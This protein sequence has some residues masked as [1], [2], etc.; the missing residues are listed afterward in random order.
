M[1]GKDERKGKDGGQR[2]ATQNQSTE[3][4]GNA[5]HAGTVS[6]SVMVHL[7]ILKNCIHNERI[8]N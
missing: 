4:T 8:K 6:G 3:T 7:P 2:K 1:K 5:S